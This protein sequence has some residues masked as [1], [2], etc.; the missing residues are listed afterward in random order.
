MLG[1]GKQRCKAISNALVYSYHL[2][3]EERNKGLEKSTMQLRK[4]NNDSYR[5]INNLSNKSSTL[6]DELK[7]SA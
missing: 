4:V 5:H 7:Q 1:K 3:I 6:R 2:E